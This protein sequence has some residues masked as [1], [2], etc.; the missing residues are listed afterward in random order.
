MYKMNEKAEVTVKSPLTECIPFTA[1]RLVMQGKVLGP[2]F[3][4]VSTDEY[5]SENPE[6]GVQV[7]TLK[8]GPLGLCG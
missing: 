7:V 6:A 2:A 5:C 3:C 1:T 4:S 8:V